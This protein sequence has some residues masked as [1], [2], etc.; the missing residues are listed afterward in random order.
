MTSELLFFFLFSAEDGAPRCS[1]FGTKTEHLPHVVMGTKLIKHYACHLHTNTE[2]PE[3]YPT[4]GK[5]RS[6]H[7]KSR[8]VL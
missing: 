8:Q 3:G 2:R 6:G 5:I 4:W 7:I 1:D